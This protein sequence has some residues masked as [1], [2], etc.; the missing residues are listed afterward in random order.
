MAR[1]GRPPKPTALKILQGNPGKRPLPKD[2]PRPEA[3]TPSC[4][5]FLS[6]GAKAEWRRIVPELEALGLLT[7][8]DRAALAAYCQAYAR[9]KEAEA[10]LT[11]NGTTYVSRD[12]DG[13]V[14]FV[15]PFPQVSIAQKQSQLMHRFLVEFGLTPSSRTRVKGIAPDPDAA[16]KAQYRAFL[17]GPAAARPGI[18]PSAPTGAPRARPS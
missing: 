18:P 12:K 7:K 17:F 3:K 1:R 2:E 15:A 9:W 10:F 14:K 8:V 5:R 6:G 13:K 16:R 4:P 11:E